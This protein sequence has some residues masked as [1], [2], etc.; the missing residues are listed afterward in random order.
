MIVPSTTPG[1]DLKAV[2]L[3]LLPILAL[4]AVIVVFLGTGTGTGL[5]SAPPVESLITERY[6]LRRGVI[7]LEVRNTGPQALTISQLIINARFGLL[8]RRR[9]RPSPA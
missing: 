7:V 2:A 5:E 8:R 9:R 3:F 4:I 6:N 1:I